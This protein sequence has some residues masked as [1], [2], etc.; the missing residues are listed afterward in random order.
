[1]MCVKSQPQESQTVILPPK[2]PIPEPMLKILKDV[3]S[4]SPDSYF[5]SKSKIAKIDIHTPEEAYRQITILY[6]EKTKMV[7]C[8]TVLNNHFIFS[9]GQTEKMKNAYLYILYVPIG[10]RKFGYYWPHT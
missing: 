9:L 1:M 3:I 6:P 10:G 8:W 5:P 7:E 4:S 2:R